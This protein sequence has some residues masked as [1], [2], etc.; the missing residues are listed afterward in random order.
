MA[1]TTRLQDVVKAP[2]RQLKIA[3][4]A[5][6]ALAVIALGISLVWPPFWTWGV[7]VGLAWLIIAVL[8]H[9]LLFTRLYAKITDLQASVSLYSNLPA[10][11][12]FKGGLF[13]DG[14]SANASFLLFLWKCLEVCRPKAILELGSGQTTKLLAHYFH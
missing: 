6:T 10:D 12:A 11:R 3:C 9:L 14:A 7:T 5:V 13:V 1:L 8:L 2:F 4:L